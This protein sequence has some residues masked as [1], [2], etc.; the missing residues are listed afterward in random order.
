VLTVKV[1]DYDGSSFFIAADTAELAESHERRLR[2]RATAHRCNMREVPGLGS[3]EIGPF[4]GCF[5]IDRN[6]DGVII[7]IRERSC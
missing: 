2:A 4:H 5:T 1:R 6:R 3:T 7:G